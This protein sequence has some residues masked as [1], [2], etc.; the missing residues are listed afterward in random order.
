MTESDHV[1]HHQ[2]EDTKDHHDE[3]KTITNATTARTKKTTYN[4]ENYNAMTRNTTHSDEDH[5]V[6]MRKTKINAKMKT[7]VTKSKRQ[8]TTSL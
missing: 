2:D 1:L 5:N 4:N 7:I 3:Q 6:R 8:Q